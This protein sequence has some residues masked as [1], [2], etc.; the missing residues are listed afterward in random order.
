M[1]IT[2]VTNPPKREPVAA[3]FAKT[4]FVQKQDNVVMVCGHG[5][6]PTGWRSIAHFLSE[7]PSAIPVYE[8][9]VVQIEF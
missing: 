5:Q 8:G 7:R 3:L 9:D 1:K 6:G 4:L 2:V